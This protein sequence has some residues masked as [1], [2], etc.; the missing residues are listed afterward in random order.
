[1]IQLSGFAGSKSFIKLTLLL[2]IFKCQQTI[3]TR[4]RV[5]ASLLV[6][7]WHG[8]SAWLTAR[9]LSPARGLL[10]CISYTSGLSRSHHIQERERK[11]LWVKCNSGR[12]AEVCRFVR[13]SRYFFKKIQIKRERN[14]RLSVLMTNYFPQM[15]VLGYIFFFFFNPSQKKYDKTRHKLKCREENKLRWVEIQSNSVARWRHEGKHD[16]LSSTPTF[17]F[18]PSSPSPLCPPIVLPP[19]LFCHHSV[20]STLPSLGASAPCLCPLLP[21]SS[22]PLRCSSP[23]SKGVWQLIKSP[24]GRQA[25]TPYYAGEGWGQ[26]APRA[27]R[28]WETVPKERG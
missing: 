11:C 27:E 19:P 1:M 20:S 3:T 5:I 28:A 15:C 22:F 14:L 13:H 12:I 4:R 8:V 24:G 17:F 9:G 10:F 2:H 21:C 26:F 23:H 18:I 6:V 16:Q 25:A 7:V